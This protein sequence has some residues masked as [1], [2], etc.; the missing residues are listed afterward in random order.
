MQ[1]NSHG[2]H[3]IEPPPVDPRIQALVEKYADVFQQPTGIPRDRGD[4]GHRINTQ[5][6]ATPPFRAS[7][8]MNSAEL[9]ELQKRIAELLEKGWIR[10]SHSMY[11]APVVLAR[12]ASGELR[13]CLDYRALNQQTIRDRYPLPRV[14]ELLDQLGGSA[15]YSKL[16]LASGYHQVAMHPDDIHKTAFNCRYG[17]F[18]WTVMPMGL[19]NAPSAFMR[20]MNNIFRPY[21]DKFLPCFLDDLLV[22]G[23]SMEEHLEHLEIVLSTLREHK[24]YAKRS[25]CVFGVSELSFLGHVV[26]KEG[27]KVDQSKVQAVLDWPQPKDVSQLRSFLGMANYFRRFIRRFSHRALPLTDRPCL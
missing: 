13:M 3:Q 20:M 6:G 24:L 8:R 23:S 14:D 5:P 7:Y 17:L 25:K 4:G 11:G 12:K 15:V 9:A 16:D 19:T 1:G 2:R 27:V 26:S 21:I 22:Y 10:A 18:E